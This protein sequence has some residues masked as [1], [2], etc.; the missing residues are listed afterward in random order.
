MLGVELLKL[1]GPQG[2]NAVIYRQ[3]CQGR[4]EV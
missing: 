3:E 4:A 1:K 2:E